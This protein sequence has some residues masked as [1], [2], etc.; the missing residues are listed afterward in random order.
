M[1]YDLYMQRCIQ[2]ARNGQ[3]TASPNPM[4]GSVL[5]SEGRI[6]GEGFHKIA[7]QAHAEEEAIRSVS[8]PSKLK[9]ATLFVNL[10]P[11]AHHGKTPPCADLII[12][13]EI[14]RVVIGCS[15][16]FPAV[17]G[18]GIQKLRNAG[19]E[20]IEN[21]CRDEA[22]HLNRRFFTFHLKKRPYVI[23]KWAQ[24]ADA[25]MDPQR[26][27]GYL[28]SYPVSGSVSRRLVH[29]WRAEEDAIL[30]GIGT[31]LKDN[32]R[33]TV[34]GI[35]GKNPLRIVI[36]TYNRM[37]LTSALF[38]EEGTTC[39]FN[40]QCAEGKTNDKIRRVL[41]PDSTP[42]HWLNA[43][44]EMGIH[45]V[46]VEGGK[47]ILQSFIKSGWWDEA[48]I[49]SSMVTFGSG[50]TAPVIPFS[51]NKSERIGEDHLFIY[52]RE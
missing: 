48:R 52:F 6:I 17:A 38:E 1:D 3:Q 10:E 34:R 12:K 44:Y 26:V 49:F 35:N 33:L 8:D 15:D 29:R 46:L 51:A 47:A 50:L 27:S 36:D 19:I 43:L 23:L 37:P 24:S 9:C 31:V 18:K 42:A 45:S 25:F 21:V 41:L 32:P 4:V 20:V 7:G 28:G 11:C 14:P 30:V 2:L 5:V 13:N 39:V 16:H 22:E 40:I